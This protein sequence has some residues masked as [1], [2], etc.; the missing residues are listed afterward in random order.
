M[1]IHM[2]SSIHT[3]KKYRLDYQAPRYWIDTLDLDFQLAETETRVVAISHIRRN[4]QHND[5]LILDGEALVLQGILLNG[6]PYSQYRLQPGQLILSELPDEFVLTIETVLNPAANSAL[7]GLYKSGAAF[8]TQ[9]EAE[10]FRRITYYLDRPDVLA[11]FTTRITADKT[12]YPFLLSNGNRTG[13]GELADGRHWAAW[14]DPFPKPCYLFALVAGDFDVLRDEFITRSKRKVA[15]ELYV[16][17][18]NLS[19][20]EHAMHSLK[21][22]MAWDEQRFE[23]EYDLDIYMIVAVDFF[24]MG[25]MENKGLNVFNSKFVLANSATATDTDY[26]DIERVIGHEYFHNWTGNRITCRDWFQLSLKEGLTVFRDQE[27]SAD[28]GSRAVH[29]IGNVRVM[30]GPQFAE[31]AGPMAHPIRPDVVIEMN[32]FYTLTVY[33]KGAEVIRMLHTLLGE[34]RFQQ[35]MRHYIA[36]HDGQAA[37]CEDFVL[38]MEAASGRDLGQFR[39]WYSQAGT[40]ILTVRGNYVP[41]LAQYR[42]QVSQFTPATAQQSD[43]LPL[44]IPLSIALYGQDGTCLPLIHQGEAV[45]D[46][47]EVTA[48]EQTFVFDHIHEQPIVSLLQNFSAPVKLDYPYSD[49]E[50][51]F[52]LRFAQNEF[53]RWDAG[54]MLVNKYLKSAVAACLQGE[55]LPEPVT[56]LHAFEHL[57]TDTALDKALL[58]EILTIPSETAL[59][60]QFERVDIEAIHRVREHL[61]QRLAVVLQEQWKTLYQCNHHSG[62]YSIEPQA[63]A[64]RALANLALAYLARA[65]QALANT[66][67]LA[68]YEQANNMT[69]LLAA[70][71]AANLGQLPALPHLLADF[72]HKW[73][74]DGLVMDN[75]FRLQATSQAADVLD[76]VRD[77]MAHQAFSLKN[78]NRVRA[79]I[80]T[81]AAANPLAF[82][83]KD[84]SGYRFLGQ[85]LQQLNTINPQVAARMIT[86]L[87][88]FKRLDEERVALIRAELQQLAALPDLSRDLAE[89]IDRALAQ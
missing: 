27:F 79:L 21:K 18:G 32:N 3:Q 86:P 26:F 23:L 84:G 5:P 47:L 81:F 87:I 52:L 83:A 69:D 36:Q 2:T 63:M 9:C 22:S 7:E 71:Q 28:L 78:P 75:W 37:T 4:G 40:P 25:A 42:L 62:A 34:E 31:D 46:L 57:V 88:Q 53:A 80:G 44:H 30:R 1:G 85:I 38:A 43:K 51:S 56:L 48:D 35:G 11:K 19:R 73:H 45:A 74:E 41:E 12:Q 58:V 6:A 8:C 66:W 54:Q 67:V 77:L 39:R 17:K 16:D 72:E 14:Q 68:Q 89:K 61:L 60:E 13:S 10:G 33:E 64:R 50:L 59:A 55:P 24:N 82:H 65:D 76:R 15:L 20:A 70:M 29:R 49:D